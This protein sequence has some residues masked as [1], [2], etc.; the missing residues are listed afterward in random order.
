[1]NFLR[2]SRFF[3]SK[4]YIHEVIL[5]IQLVLMF[6]FSL[7]VLGPIDNFIQYSQALK[8]VYSSID[9]SR[10]LF[11]NPNNITYDNE[12]RIN[13]TISDEVGEIVNDALD[14]SGLSDP[15]RMAY[16]SAYVNVETSDQQSLSNTIQPV[17]NIVNVLVYS[18]E[19]MSAIDN[20][21]AYENFEEEIN[22]GEIVPILISQSLGDFIPLGTKVDVSIIENDNIVP[23]IVS[24]ILS[25][26]AI[27]PAT[28]GF[29]SAPYLSNLGTKL[30][31]VPNASFI[32]V[33]YS[34][35]YFSEVSWESSFLVSV[36]ETRNEKN[37]TDTITKL[38]SKVGTWGS[39]STLQD[40][41]EQAF[42]NVLR[43]NRV[44][45][46][47]FILLSLITFFGYGGHIFILATQRQREF[48]V[49]YILG[50][51]RRKM[52]TM[53]C[54]IGCVNLVVSYLIA[55][56]CYP[57]FQNLMMGSGATTIGVV[58]IVYCLL[59]ILI[60]VI[61]SLV[62]FHRLENATTISLFRGGD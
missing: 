34:S 26:D 19:L 22:D 23:C 18:D 49:F 47:E 58:S 2:I 29:G 8:S 59:L 30:S 15:I 20:L 55:L 51:P 1:M 53:N 54:I 52:L 16:C 44:Y 60:I 50:M 46:V 57:C 11:F 13:S 42:Y 40:F 4:R 10:T 43:D 17:S 41:E 37:V 48:S 56:V 35:K 9:Y 27:L 6:S 12:G 31:D 38:N 28:H 45:M 14:I 5:I 7:I 36:E 62:A 32:V 39:F 21:G 24:G 61:S 33:R 3:Y 25:E